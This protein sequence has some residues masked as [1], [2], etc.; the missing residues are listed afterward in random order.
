MKRIFNISYRIFHGDDGAP[1]CSWCA[2][3]PEYINYHDY[4]WGFPVNDDRRLFEKISLEGFQ[5][6]LSWRTILAKRE[7]FRTAFKGFDF[8]KISK[9]TKSDVGEL[10]QDRGIIR[11]KGKIEATINNAMRAQE[12][13]REKGSLAAYF[14]SFEPDHVTR[15]QLRPISSSPMSVALSKDMKSRGWQFVGPTTTYAFMQAMGLVNDHANGCVIRDQ[16]TLARK[17][18]RVPI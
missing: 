5:A 15:T 12:L 6:G 8:Y 9:F 2:A 14:W 17:K 18:F 10:M 3:T 1:R 13:V 4:E 7:K 11:H 16:V